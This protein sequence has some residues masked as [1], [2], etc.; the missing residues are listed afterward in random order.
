MHLVK[1]KNYIYTEKEQCNPQ[2][3]MPFFFSCQGRKSGLVFG[4][5]AAV[6][7]SVGSK[8]VKYL[9]EITESFLIEI[10]K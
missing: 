8:G 3:Q 9:S 6:A 10:I 7:A 5:S 1:Y 2:W 4:L